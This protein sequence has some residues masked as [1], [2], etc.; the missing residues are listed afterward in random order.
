L[1]GKGNEVWAG[2]VAVVLANVVLVGY[3]VTAV[4]E[5][6][7]DENFVYYHKNKVA[8]EMVYE[9]EDNIG[10]ELNKEKLN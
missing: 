10:D 3:V 8:Q 1:F 7:E 4:I 9:D 5:T 2:I 6:G